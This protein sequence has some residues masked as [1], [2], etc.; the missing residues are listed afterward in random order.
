MNN[1]HRYNIIGLF[2][3]STT[4]LFSSQES[5]K[6]E[7]YHKGV[8]NILFGGMLSGLSGLYFWRALHYSPETDML[9][10]TGLSYGSATAVKGA[11]QIMESTH[12][13]SP[14]ISFI[15]RVANSC[16]WSFGLLGAFRFTFLFPKHQATWD[17]QYDLSN[18]LSQIVWLGSITRLKYKIDTEMKRM[19]YVSKAEVI[20]FVAHKSFGGDTAQIEDALNN[21]LKEKRL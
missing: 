8:K 15:S 11:T 9:A 4:V 12:G 21:F 10:V 18:H 14:T 13:K 3:L 2:L 20:Q 5:Q 7:L 6:I 16:Q 1:L 17:V 19:G